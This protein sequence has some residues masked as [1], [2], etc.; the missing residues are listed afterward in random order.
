MYNVHIMYKCSIIKCTNIKRLRMSFETFQKIHQI[1][2]NLFC[3][4][5]RLKHCIRTLLIFFSVFTGLC[6]IILSIR[7]VAKLIMIFCNC[8]IHLY[9]LITQHNNQIQMLNISLIDPF[10]NFLNHYLGPIL[11]VFKS[12]A[13]AVHPFLFRL[14]CN[15]ILYSHK[16]L[17]ESS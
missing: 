4:V 14:I 17:Q 1:I 10:P 7:K 16:S 13:L 9:F 8:W 15:T 2:Q 5:D 3:V 11:G 6:A 12:H